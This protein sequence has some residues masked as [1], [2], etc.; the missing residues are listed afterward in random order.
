MKVG[1]LV[2]GRESGKIGV[3]VDIETWYGG[4]NGKKPYHCCLMGD[5]RI[6]FFGDDLEVIA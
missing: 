5:D 2:K 4:V 1:D 6:W 3:I